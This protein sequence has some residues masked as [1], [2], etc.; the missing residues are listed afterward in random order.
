M[1]VYD[2]PPTNV[3]PL[4]SQE[5]SVQSP[6]HQE[7]YQQQQYP[8]HQQQQQQTGSNDTSEVIQW[9]EDTEFLCYT[10]EVGSIQFIFDVDIF[11]TRSYI[12]L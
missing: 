2:E 4:V 12:T 10:E 11:N 8:Q 7:P 9:A 3:Q 1:E 6:D 5:V